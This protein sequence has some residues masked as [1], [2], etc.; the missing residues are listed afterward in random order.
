[1]LGDLRIDELAARRLEAFKRAFLV[2]PQ[3]TSCL[4]NRVFRKDLLGRR[5]VRRDHISQSAAALRRFGCCHNER[6]R[7]GGSDEQRRCIVLI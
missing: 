5:G 1:V 2:R 3:P 6:R 4:R 7:T